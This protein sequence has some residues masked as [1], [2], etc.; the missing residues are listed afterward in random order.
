MKT[1]VSKTSL[2]AALVAALAL[3]L[4]T[5]GTGVA[6]SAQDPQATPETAIAALPQDIQVVDALSRV[7]RAVVRHVQPSIVFIGTESKS[8]Q[9]GAETL[10]WPWDDPDLQQLLPEPFRRYRQTPQRQ[11]RP[12]IRRGLGSGFIILPDGWIVTNNH[13]VEGADKV[14][15]KLEGDDQ[16]YVATDIR[17]DPKSDVAV[18]KISVNRKLPAISF[19]DSDALEVGD[20]VMAFGNPLGL[21]H[22][23]S[24]G[25]VSAKGREGIYPRQPGA[26]KIFYENFIQTDAAINRGNSGGPLVNMH[27]EV[28]GLNTLIATPYN[29]GIGFAIPSN[30]AKSVVDDLIAKG[31]VTRGWLGIEMQ[32]WTPQLRDYLGVKEGGV[33]VGK[34]LPGHPA[35]KAG[36]KP[37][38]VLLE[39]NGVKIDDRGQLQRLVADTAPDSTV[40]ILLQRDGKQIPVGVAVGE[41]K[42]EEIASAE[43]APEEGFG[44]LGIRVEDL[45]PDEARSLGLQEKGGVVIRDVD[46]EGVAAEVGLEPGMVILEV[47]QETV[48]SAAEMN[49]ALKKTPKD[50]GVLLKVKSSA[51]EF[52]TVLQRAKKE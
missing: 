13:V 27:G 48:A 30:L 32:S 33:L 8:S 4:F 18:L 45:T 42:D 15:V 22:T 9:Q 2:I 6:L 25:V 46:P 28:V 24:Q 39:Y 38:D 23:V 50:K 26:Q 7:S 5:W 20:W 31:R 14:F 19:G 17:R 35:E 16:Q 3:G 1:H 29:I 52:Y 43:Q 10:P 37:L 11:M 51:G 49:A 44:E 41:Q 34:V 12:E 47:N 40:K 21:S 36:L